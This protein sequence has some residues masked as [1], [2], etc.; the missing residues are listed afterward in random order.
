LRADFFRAD[1]FRA[2]DLRPDDF[3]ALVR[4]APRLLALRA[5]PRFAPRD[6]DLRA[7]DFRPPDLPPDAPPFLPVFEPPRDFL[8]AIVP[9][10]DVGVLLR[11]YSNFRAQITT[12]VLR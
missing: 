5:P 8:A 2:D 11:H 12:A 9:S 3:E 7:A 10:S 1:D 4:F 6:E